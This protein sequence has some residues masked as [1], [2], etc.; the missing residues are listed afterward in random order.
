MNRT[1][2]T[3]AVALAAMGLSA[4]SEHNGRMAANSKICT[5][6]KASTTALAIAD[7]ATPVDECLRR[8]SYSLASAH[9]TAE[10]VAEAAVAAC[11]TTLSRWNQAGLGQQQTQAGGPVEALSLTTGQP[12]N[13]IAEHN[14]FARGRALLYVVQARAGRCAPPPATN[15]VPAGT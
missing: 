2:L 12:T 15:G 13:A 1:T 5:S 14:N 10:V 11:G 6:F 4:C 7:A 9:D 8:W 3:A